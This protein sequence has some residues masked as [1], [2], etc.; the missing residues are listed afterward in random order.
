VATQAVIVLRISHTS[1]S[2]VASLHVTRLIKTVRLVTAQAMVVLRIS[3]A[4]APVIA[5][6]PR[7]GETFRLVPTHAVVVLRIPHAATWSPMVFLIF[8][9][10]S[11]R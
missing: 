11:L 5:T 8:I 2:I 7:F 10:I 6:M 9:A 1:A 3:H 4:S